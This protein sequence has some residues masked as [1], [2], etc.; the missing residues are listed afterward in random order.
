MYERRPSFAEC[1]RL[2]IVEERQ[3]L[4]VAP[5][6]RRATCERVARPGTRGVE[7]V[8]NE[9]RRAALAEMVL[10]SGIERRRAAGNATLEMREVRHLPIQQFCVFLFL[11]IIDHRDVM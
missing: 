7:I 3:Q 9:Q 6:I 2:L 8:T 1:E 4:A 11:Q 10:A 5:H